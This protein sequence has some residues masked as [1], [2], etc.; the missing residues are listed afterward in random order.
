MTTFFAACL[1]LS[2]VQQT[3][4]GVVRDQSGGVVSG[5][6]V[7]VRTDSGTEAQTVTG[8]DGRFTVE[9]ASGTGATLVIRAGG[10]AEKR[11]PVSVSEAL[12]IGLAPATLLETVT[13]TP[14]RTEERIGNIP[15]SISVIDTEAIREL[16][17]GGGRRRAAAGADLQLVPPYQQSVVASDDARRVV[18]RHRPE[19]RQPVRSS[20]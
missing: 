19:R 3:V 13:V 9:A 16:A 15:A 20:W 14:S 18:A 12:E 6:T 2:L 11:Q 5:A 8:P 4:T 1:A 10:F 17:R 7:I